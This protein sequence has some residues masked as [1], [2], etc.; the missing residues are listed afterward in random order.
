M[1]TRDIMNESREHYLYQLLYYALIEIRD[2]AHEKKNSKIFLLADL[3]HNIP[4]RLS[5]A[6]QPEDFKAIFDELEDRATKR[7]INK[8]L[9]NTVKQL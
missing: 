4:S 9:E 8:W 6:S 7:G 2:E 3:F 5:E 1:Q